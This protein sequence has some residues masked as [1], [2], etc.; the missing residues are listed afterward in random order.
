M[1]ISSLNI[2]I[3][4]GPMGVQLSGG[5]DSAILFYILMMYAKGPIHVFSCANGTT[6]NREPYGALNVIN[7]VRNRIDRADVYFH[8]FWVDN[9]S[10]TNIVS[11]ELIA[12]TGIQTLYMGFTRPPPEGAITNYDQQ[13]N[14]AIGGVDSGV[15]LPVYWTKDML[16]DVPAWLQDRAEQIVQNLSVPGYTPFINVNKQKIAELY[17][18]LDVDDLYSN[19]RSCES[20]TLTQGHCGRCWWCK[21]RMWAFGK[22]Q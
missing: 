19:T 1:N 5:A 15:D 18:Y 12:M 7:W 13:G 11:A 2:D 21:E 10:Y 20:L 6:N 8:S 14:I 17:S 9:K 22:L 4:E 3:H 16:V